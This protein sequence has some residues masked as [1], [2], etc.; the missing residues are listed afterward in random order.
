MAKPAANPVAAHENRLAKERS[1]YLRQHAH[2]PV[3]WWPWGKEAFAKAKADDKPVFLSIGYAACHWCHV[4]AHESFEDE[5]TAAVLNETCV[6]VKVDREERPDVD[7]VYMAAVQVTTGHGGWP[8]SVFLTPDGKPFLARTYMPAATLRS[9]AAQMHRL[10]TEDR[11][12]LLAV[13]EE[14]AD[15][16]RRMSAGP[17]DEAA[18]RSDADLVRSAL[19]RLSADFDRER[20][21]FDRAPKFPP[22]AA[23]RLLLDRGGAAGGEGG[24]AMARRTLDAMASG[25]VRDLVGGGFHRYSTDANWFVPHFEKMLYDNALLARSYLDAHAIGGEDRD[26]RYAQVA[27]ET[28]LWIVREMSVEGGGYASSLDADTDHEEGAT[29]TWTTDEIRAALPPADAALAIRAFGAKEGGNY[30]EEA[31]G[32]GTGRNILSLPVPLADLAREGGVPAGRPGGDAVAE[33]AARLDRIRARLLE[34]RAERAQP[35]RDD[36]V[37]VAWNG[38][39]LSA[40]SRAGTVLA[41]PTWTER[42][43]ALAT[44]LLDRCRDGDRLLR[45]PKGSGSRVLGFLD[46][47]A[48][49]ADGLLDLAETTGDRRW[50]DEAARLADAILARFSDPAGGFFS[51]GDDHEALLARPKDLFDS[52]IPSASA[53]AARV[54]LRLCVLTGKAAYREACD[55]AIA[56]ARP[57]VLRAPTATLAFVRVVAD[58]AALGAAGA[59]P[60]P[61]DVSLRRDPAAVDVFLDRGEARPG[62]RVRVLV[63]LTLDPGFR[64]YSAATLATLAKSPA[65]LVDAGMAPEPGPSRPPGGAYEIRGAL[66]IP[67]EAPPGPRKVPLILTF[68]ACDESSCRAP[69]EVRIDV[70]LRFSDADGP[71]RHPLSFR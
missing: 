67:A 6:C 29:Y 4:M 48:H 28:L 39:L 51:T 3:D 61:G 59:A 71:P 50:S 18:S 8:M 5:A 70:P 53:T 69:E 2:N 44:F 23:L 34:V 15:A 38:L 57:L 22:H 60:E 27:R 14:V 35:G 36:K 46:D 41:D 37:I 13:A 52:P 43:V 26:G 12:R 55:R 21:G 58:R 9:V 25:G 16:V 42:A 40:F 17:E 10:W 31:T 30:A 1:P 11:A 49:L 20:G 56:A 66:A 24:L 68:Q 65:T 54:L 19:D 63:R 62:T 47:H 33:L 32:R 64:L 7:D 45:L